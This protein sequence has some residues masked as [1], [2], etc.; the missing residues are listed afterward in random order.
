M[1]LAPNVYFDVYGQLRPVGFRPLAIAMP[2]AQMMLWSPLMARHAHDFHFDVRPH[3]KTGQ[4]EIVDHAYDQTG[5]RVR[6]HRRSKVVT[7]VAVL[8]VFGNCDV[9][10]LALRLEYSSYWH[11]YLPEMGT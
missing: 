5:R 6:P 3:W 7:W 8:A 4:P 11:H 2:S 1:T 9:A 10:K